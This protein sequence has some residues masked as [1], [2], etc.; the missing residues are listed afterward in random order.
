MKFD[1]ALRDEGSII[2]LQP[3]TQAAQDWAEMYLADALRFGAAVVIEH[4]Y[5]DAIL[6]G[7]REAGLTV[8]D[9][10]EGKIEDA[11]FTMQDAEFLKDL[12]VKVFE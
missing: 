1:F 5:I 11:L 3:V 2:L 4:R 10:L 9:I 12:G 8:V 7:I 6:D